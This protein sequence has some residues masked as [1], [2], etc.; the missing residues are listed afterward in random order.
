MCKTF[1]LTQKLSRRTA[2][3]CIH[4]FS[5]CFLSPPESSLKFLK[6]LLLSV[7][8][9]K[10][11]DMTIA[12]FHPF[13]NPL[14]YKWGMRNEEWGMKVSPAVMIIYCRGEHCLP[15]P[16]HI[17]R[18]NISVWDDALGVPLGGATLWFFVSLI[19]N[20]FWGT[21]LWYSS[22]IQWAR[23]AGCR[24]RQPLHGLWNA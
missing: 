22:L 2:Q 17:C 16:T 20:Y 13:V 23:K 21:L 11:I 18:K 6:R 1:R 8:A 5:K 7:T 12:H 9:F 19:S 24:G 4:T 3:E 15:T 14:F 10:P